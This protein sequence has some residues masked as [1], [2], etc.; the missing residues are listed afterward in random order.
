MSDLIRN[1][2]LPCE[3]D[4]MYV[5]S[6]NKSTVSSGVI[7]I[8]KDL[9]IDISNYDVLIIEDILDTGL[10][11]ETLCKLLQTRNQIH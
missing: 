7:N 1:I 6:Y 8:V 2:D 5:K 10:T 11:L 4:F 9:S 3:I